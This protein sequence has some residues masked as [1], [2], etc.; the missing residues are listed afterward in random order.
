MMMMMTMFL[1]TLMVLIKSHIQEN[2]RRL[3]KKFTKNNQKQH[4][5]TKKNLLKENKK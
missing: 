2:K 1:V 5:K 3:G 4:K